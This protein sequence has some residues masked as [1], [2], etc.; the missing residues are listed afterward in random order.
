M[1]MRMSETGNGY[2]PQ[3]LSAL[4]FE[5]TALTEP[6]EHRLTQT[7][8]PVNPRICLPP[9]HLLWDYKHALLSKLFFFFCYLSFYVGAEDQRAQTHSLI[10]AL[11]LSHL[12]SLCFA[13]S[14]CDPY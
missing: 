2:L 1:S 12:P 13:F 14:P 4:F 10:L 3:T 8:W 9:P 11:R 6:G 5:T 7:S